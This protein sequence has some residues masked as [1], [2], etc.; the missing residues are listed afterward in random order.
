M[1]DYNSKLQIT[2]RGSK[3]S[4]TKRCYSYLEIM[5]I[6]NYIKFENVKIENIWSHGCYVL[7]LDNYYIFILISTAHWIYLDGTLIIKII[8]ILFSILNIFIQDKLL[9]IFCWSDL[10]FPACKIFGNSRF[11]HIWYICIVCKKSLI[12]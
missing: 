7:D 6:F 9:C 11:N 1:F 5:I 2:K 12:I 8:V 10:L 3:N 4:D